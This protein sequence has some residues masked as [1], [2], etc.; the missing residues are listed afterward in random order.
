MWP[1]GWS[2]H[3]CLQTTEVPLRT[4]FV[5]V[6]VPCTGIFF[7]M[8]LAVKLHYSEI[9]RLIPVDS[10]SP[11]K[12]LQIVMGQLLESCVGPSSA[13]RFMPN[14]PM[15]DL[16]MLL[17]HSAHSQWR[18]TT[19][20]SGNAIADRIAYAHAN[21]KILCRDDLDGLQTKEMK[22]TCYFWKP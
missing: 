8:A 19:T 14:D 13:L 15:W 7:V 6:G 21:P 4:N 1:S 11:D 22:M 9:N 18:I 2:H 16:N 12:L 5:K 3:N 10:R 17:A 20:F